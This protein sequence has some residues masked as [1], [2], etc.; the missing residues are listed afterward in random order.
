MP[1]VG[2]ARTVDSGAVQLDP[3][4]VQANN[5]PQ[6]ADIGNLPPAFAGGEVARGSR[7]GI[8]GNRD[9]MDTPFSTTT[10]TQQYIQDNQA[11]TDDRR[12]G[13]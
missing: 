3:V 2:S 4:R 7:V 6:Q 5:P 12:R 13:R 1:F 10:Y 8:L 11:R 9:Y